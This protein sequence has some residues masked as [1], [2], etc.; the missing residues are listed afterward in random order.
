MTSVD[1]ERF[2][3]RA[4]ELAERGRYSV[5]PNPMVGCVLVRNGLIVGEGWHE[6]A[7]E[8][9]AEVQALQSCDDP[10]G[11]TMYA[12]LEPCMHFGRTP[13]CSEV[14]RNAGIKRVIV[15]TS[16]PHDIV[17][18]RGLVQ[19]RDAGIAVQTGIL[20]KDAKRLNEKF[21][22]AVTAKKPFVCIKAAMTLDG[23]LATVARDSKWI[24]SD[25]ARQKSLE[26]REEYDAILVGGGTV[27]EDDPQLTR[28]LGWNNAIT[29]WTRVVLDRDSRVPPTAKIL[30][31]GGATLHLTRDVDLKELLSDLYQRGIQSLMVEGG[32]VVI[33]EFIHLNIWQKMVIFVAPTLVGGADAPSIFG[34]QPAQ[35]L[36]DAH[37]FRGIGL[38]PRA[39]FGRCDGRRA[40]AAARDDG[41]PPDRHSVRRHRAAR[42]G[43]GRVSRLDAGARLRIQASDDVPFS[44]GESVAVN[45]V[46]LTVIPTGDSVITEISNE[47]LTRTTLGTLGSGARVNLERA[48]SV[49]DRVGGHFVQGHI[50]T[51]GILI[52]RK[53]EGDFAVYRWTF[54]REFSELVVSKGSIAVDGVSLTIVDPDESSFAAALIPETLRRTTLGTARIG[55]RM[56]LEFDMIAKYVRTLVAPYIV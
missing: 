11:A 16:D 15:A 21:L 14:I 35:R 53:S 9:H 25:A 37:R 30:T 34:G 49:G 43:G 1:D 40:V 19:L 48:L 46:C 17:N 32:S 38:D 3:R 45:G 2:M 50:D 20:E 28:R 12:T 51:T 42:D 55:E 39:R 29:P 6:R 44:R 23:K 27:Y 33:S 8:P 41:R 26:L 36:T 52:S 56:N 13:P 7:G 5:S 18:G 31:D 24:T 54:P 4:L 22:H 10:T 47:T